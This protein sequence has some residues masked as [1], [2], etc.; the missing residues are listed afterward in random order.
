MTSTF[1]TVLL[2]INIV[3]FFTLLVS[4]VYKDVDSKYSSIQKA[5]GAIFGIALTQ[6]AITFVIE[7]SNVLP[8]DS[9]TF[10]QDLR[11]VDWI[12]TTPLLLYTYWKLADIEGFETE[13]FFIILADIVMIVFG[14]LAEIFATD[15]KTRLICFGIGTLGYVYI[16]IQVI[17]I[18]SYFNDKNMPKH[19]NLGYFFIF[20][21]ALYPIGFFLGDEAKYSLYSIG[22]FINKGLYSLFLNELI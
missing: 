4:N 3:F 18:M 15:R 5:E 8:V 16:L 6:Y 9:T 12:V 2:L 17:R 1:L 7:N 22:D 19:A 11:Y 13:L 21:W 14:A 20:G 10:A